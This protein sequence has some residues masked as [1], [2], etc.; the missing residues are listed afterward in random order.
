MSRLERDARYHSSQEAAHG[1]TAL[2]EE[3]RHLLNR[4]KCLKKQ[5]D[6][7]GQRLGVKKSE[8][9]LAYFRACEDRNNRQCWD[10][11]L[12]TDVKLAPCFHLICPGCYQRHMR[13]RTSPHIDTGPVEQQPFSGRAIILLDEI[14]HEVC[15]LQGSRL[16][17]SPWGQE[18]LLQNTR[19]LKEHCERLEE[20]RAC[21]WREYEKAV[22]VLDSAHSKATL[23]R[24]NRPCEGCSTICHE[25]YLAPCFHLL[26]GACYPR[27][28][29]FYRACH[30]R[31]PSQTIG[32]HTS[33]SRLVSN[34]SSTT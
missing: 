15:M 19:R 26:C 6:L 29:D 23:D 17:A 7:A 28:K 30:H 27:P 18:Y 34:F 21:T 20:R 9:E 4:S 8:L 3:Y 32:S 10:C 31:P 25:V 24:R 1:R 2:W 16:T 22:A 11:R 5:V 12:W 13:C 14:F 33:G